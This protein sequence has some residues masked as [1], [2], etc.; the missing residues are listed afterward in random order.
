MFDRCCRGGEWS[1]IRDVLCLLL[2]LSHAYRSC[3][4]KCGYIDVLKDTKLDEVENKRVRREPHGF[5]RQS[6]FGVIGCVRQQESRGAV[7]TRKYQMLLLVTSGLHEEAL[8]V[9]R[10]EAGSASL[11]SQTEQSSRGSAIILVLYDSYTK[12]RPR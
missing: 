3:G 10:Y 2:T 4:A 5:R 7:T 6:A 8:Y 9:I 1:N 12:H 11:P